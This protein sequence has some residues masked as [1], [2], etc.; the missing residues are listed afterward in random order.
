MANP[1]H[2]C[3]RTKK[4]AIHHR[5]KGAFAL[6]CYDLH[7]TVQYCLSNFKAQ[8]MPTRDLPSTHGT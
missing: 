6:Y 3:I 4:G 7:D 1:G 2:L 8:S 5:V